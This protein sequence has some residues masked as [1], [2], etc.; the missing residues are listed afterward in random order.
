MEHIRHRSVKNF[1]INPWSA[2]LAYTSMD[3]FPTMLTYVHKLDPTKQPEIVHPNVAT[4]KLAFLP[5]I[6]LL[7]NILT[8][9]A[10]GALQTNK[11]MPN[12]KEMTVN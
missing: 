1:F 3:S 12:Y 4:P 2:I 10:K 11:T 9:A 6:E 5:T 7:L 8:S